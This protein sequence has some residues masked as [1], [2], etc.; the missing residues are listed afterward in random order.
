MR[1]SSKVVRGELV[2]K[3][4]MERSLGEEGQTQRGDFWEAPE[5]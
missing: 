3:T 4:K 2:F 1:V 5:A